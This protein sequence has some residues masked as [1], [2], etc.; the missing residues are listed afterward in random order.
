M[1]YVLHLADFDLHLVQKCA[2]EAP[3]KMIQLVVL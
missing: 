1:S 2:T 3:S